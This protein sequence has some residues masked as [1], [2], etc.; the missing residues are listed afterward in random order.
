MIAQHLQTSPDLSNDAL[1]LQRAGRG[2]VVAICADA[3]RRALLLAT[4]GSLIDEIDLGLFSVC[5]TQL[6]NQL[7]LSPD[8]L[9]MILMARGLAGSLSGV[10]WG[11]LADRWD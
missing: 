2:R 4:L 9:G 8:L 5:F 3:M 11:S 7:S 1:W 6:E 10:F